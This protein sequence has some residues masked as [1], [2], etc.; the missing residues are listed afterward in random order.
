MLLRKRRVLGKSKLWYVEK[1]TFFFVCVCGIL[2]GGICV[3]KFLFFI[4]LAFIDN[5]VSQ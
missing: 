2:S 4:A 3:V 5:N 1:L